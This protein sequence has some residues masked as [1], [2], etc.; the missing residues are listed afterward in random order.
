MKKTTNRR[1]NRR[2]GILRGEE[3]GKERTRKEAIEME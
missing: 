1:K 2:E 3:E